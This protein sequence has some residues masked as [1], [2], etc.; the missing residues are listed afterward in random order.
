[1]PSEQRK[2]AVYRNLPAVIADELRE[3][4]LNG[5]IE[6]GNKLK[7]E[8]IAGRFNSS[9]IPVREALRNL[10]AEGLVTF[11]PNKGAFVS[12]L[13]ATAIREIFETRIF[14][15]QGAL[16]LS[17]PNL[18]AEDLEQAEAALHQL[19]LT[20]TGRDLS[21]Y[22]RIFHRT[23]Y[24]RCGN[25]YLLALIDTL[26]RNIER[27]MRRYL[28]DQYN[29]EQSQKSHRDIVKAVRLGDT[30]AAKAALKVHMDTAVERLVLAL[31]Q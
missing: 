24:S 13:S 1:M 18:I 17:I 29:N 31:P 27:Y 10:E 15:E 4:I 20:D 2:P 9:L 14:L 3:A 26:H 30:A 5:E 19:D 28:A 8:E 22:N 21:Y 23:L 12:T 16:E 25:D 7:Q 6:A 11:F